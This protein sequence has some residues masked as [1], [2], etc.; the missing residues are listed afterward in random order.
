MPKIWQEICIEKPEFIERIF[1]VG[2][3]GTAPLL[4]HSPSG[5]GEKKYARGVI[6]SPEEEAKNALYT[7]CDGNIIVPARCIEGALVKS[8][9]AKSAP[10][11]GKKTF[12]QFVLGGLQVIPEEVPLISDPYIIDKRRCVIM[13]QG[14]IRCRPR[15]NEWKL[16][17]DIK[18][19]DAYL[20]GHG[21]DANLKMIIEDAG[22]LVGLLDYRP[23]FGR[24]KVTKFEMKSERRP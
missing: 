14:I 4:M 24:F 22:S 18:I 9:S 10:G 6:P 21:M 8:A 23:K 3:E 7:D 15:F 5:L 19:I 16:N 1:S 13:R 2:V 20:L 17:F 12:K 11:Q